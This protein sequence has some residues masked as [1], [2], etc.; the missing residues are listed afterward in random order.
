VVIESTDGDS[1]EGHEKRAAPFGSVRSDGLLALG[2]DSF[3][4]VGAGDRSLLAGGEILQG[5][6]A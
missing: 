5:E 3:G 4:Q 2:L 1:R 6:L